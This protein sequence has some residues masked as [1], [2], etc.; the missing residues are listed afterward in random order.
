MV[1]K[2]KKYLLKNEASALTI[3]NY[4]GKIKT[5]LKTVPIKEIN[6]EKIEEFILKLKEKRKP[7]TVNNY[8]SVIQSFLTFLKKD[9]PIPKQKKP[10]TMLPDNID[11]TFFNKE[12]IPVIECIFTNPL[13]IK[14][15][16][17]FILYTGVRRRELTNLK[18]EHINITSRTAKIF[19]KGAKER[20]VFFTKEVA[21]MLQQYFAVEPE[22]L[23]TFNINYE[24]LK[25]VF[26]KA[27]PYF[28]TI[29]FRC[30]LLRHSFATIF[31]NNGGDIATLSRLLGHSSITT[32]MRYIGV[33]TTKM[34]ELYDKNIG[35]K[36]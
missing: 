14:T 18:R 26:T 5:F 6:E 29:N 12:I 21:E 24:A 7:S 19:G 13:K 4:I 32:T 36:K 11:E 20:V 28:K 25:K 2:Y 17:Y 34:K 15:I 30:H 16:M 23:N 22:I 31:I 10:P 8:K 27:K 1:E 33:E 35:R 3:A 9:I